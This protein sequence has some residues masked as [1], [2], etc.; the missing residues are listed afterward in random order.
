LK[1]VDPHTSEREI[2]QFFKAK[3]E[4]SRDELGI[5]SLS[6]FTRQILALLNDRMF[7]LGV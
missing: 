3:P 2:F 7:T 4:A 1:S 5:S 6:S